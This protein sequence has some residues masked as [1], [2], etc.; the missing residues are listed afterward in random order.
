MKRYFWIRL[1][2]SLAL[3]LA[4]ALLGVTPGLS[5]DAAYAQVP[6]PETFTA[7]NPCAAT[8]NTQW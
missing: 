2:V 3:G 4:L 6:P 7:N 1:A 5:I 8:S